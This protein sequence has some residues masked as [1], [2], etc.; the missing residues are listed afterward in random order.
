MHLREHH[1]TGLAVLAFAAWALL[2]W[3]PGTTETAWVETFRRQTTI[4]DAMLPSVLAMVMAMLGLALLLAKPRE[5]RPVPAGTWRFAAALAALGALWWLLLRHTGPGLVALAQASGAEHQG[6]RALRD[7]LPW[8][9]SG[10]VL[11]SAVLM[12]GLMGLA[13]GRWR[14][15]D[16][17]WGASF[18]LALAALVMGPF[19]HLQLP[20]N[21][22]V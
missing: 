6:Y 17:V 4:G 22:N 11:A 20:P 5:H 8:S 7:T 19:A 1:V 12:A 21:A 16:L 3:I 10:H 2:W 18:A 13:R 9:V 14:W 15:L